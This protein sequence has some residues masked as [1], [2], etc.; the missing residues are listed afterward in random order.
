MSR[1]IRVARDAVLEALT[2]EVGEQMIEFLG[3]EGDL[4]SDARR[5]AFDGG[6]ASRNVGSSYHDGIDF[7]RVAIAVTGRDVDVVSGAK[8]SAGLNEQTSGGYIRTNS[9]V[10]LPCQREFAHEA[11]DLAWVF[12]SFLPLSI[13]YHA[14][15]IELRGQNFSVLSDGVVKRVSLRKLG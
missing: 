6:D 15:M 9:R 5:C 12:P 2:H 4:E 14:K 7:D 13:R 11:I 10:A 8:R 3:G 1:C